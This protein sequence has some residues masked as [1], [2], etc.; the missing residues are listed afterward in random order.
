MIWNDKPIEIELD[1]LDTTPTDFTKIARDCDVK[2]LDRVSE[3]LSQRKDKGEHN[4]EN[5]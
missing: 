3:V 4:A 5:N 2:S 1:E